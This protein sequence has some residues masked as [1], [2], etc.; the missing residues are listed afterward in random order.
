MIASRV[1][2]VEANLDRCLRETPAAGRPLAPDAPLAPG[3]SLPAGRAVALFE[4]QLVSRALD[5]EARRLKQRGA[6]YYTIASA[7]HEQNAILGAQLRLSDP[8]LLHYRSGA[9]MMARARQQP[10][11]DPIRDTLLSLVAAA[12]DPIAAGRHKVWGSRKLWVPPQT[13]IRR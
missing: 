5:V 11:I 7:G 2:I 1:E 10:G 9:F 12:E 8:A 4:D 6:G 13:S 3:S